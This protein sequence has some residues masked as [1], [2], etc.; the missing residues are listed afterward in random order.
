MIQ[1]KHVKK[2]RVIK[3]CGMSIGLPAED[4]GTIIVGGMMMN[5]W[6][7]KGNYGQRN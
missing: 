4:F 3:D 6:K 5:R 2:G 7:G 1:T